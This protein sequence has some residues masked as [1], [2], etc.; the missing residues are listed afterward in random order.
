MK[1]DTLALG[2]K[3]GGGQIVVT[4]VLCINFPEMTLAEKGEL[5]RKLTDWANNLRRTTTP[6]GSAQ[7]AAELSQPQP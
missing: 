7:P 4:D 5:S 1:S 2:Y 3:D 6:H